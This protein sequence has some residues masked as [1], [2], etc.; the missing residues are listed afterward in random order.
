MKQVKENV[1]EDGNYWASHIDSSSHRTW[2]GYA[3]E[4]VCLHHIR[5][6]KA[7]I[8]ISGVAT[9]VSSWLGMENGKKSGQIDL[10]IDRHD[11][12]I[13]LCE[14]K[15]SV[16]KFEIKP[17]YLERMIGRKEAFRDA[18]K[19]KKALHLTMVTVNG[20]VHNAQWN[21]IQNEVTAEQLFKE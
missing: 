14:M 16:N 19:T 15:Y 4:Q 5:Q 12:T 7:A 10:V 13:N 21:D 18:T 17:S 11:E 6:I 2:S 9:Q 8:G 1:I 3:F 20:V